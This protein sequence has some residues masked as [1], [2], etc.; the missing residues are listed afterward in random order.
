MRK[1]IAVCISL[2]ALVIGGCEGGAS[3]EPPWGLDGIVP[4]ADEASIARVFEAMPETVHGLDRASVGR[5]GVSY[6]ETQRVQIS[7][8][9][10]ADTAQAQG[11]PATAGG[12]LRLLDDSGELDVETRA[13]GEAADV[14]YLIATT[15][16][17]SELADGTIVNRRTEYLASWGAPG[18]VW[19]FG[20]KADSSEHRAALAQA[21]VEALGSVPGS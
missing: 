1:T 20:I 2:A 17:A 11:F 18:S 12:Y 13:L 15:T 7:A 9:Q 3:D 4:P 5:L 10:L 16:S 21:F 19:L 6:G 14:A 8:M